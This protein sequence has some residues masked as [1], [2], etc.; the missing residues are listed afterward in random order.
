MSKSFS[1]TNSNSLCR[2]C[3]AANCGKRKKRKG[4]SVQPSRE[5]KIRIWG[6]NA[7]LPP[8]RKP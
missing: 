7:K 6:A 4:G 8:Y 2:C 3:A 5:A 1:D